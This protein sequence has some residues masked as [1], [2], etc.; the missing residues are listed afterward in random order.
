MGKRRTIVEFV[1]IDNV[2]LWVSFTEEKDNMGADE[3]SAAGDQN[4][5]RCVGGGGGD[6]WWGGAH[7]LSTW[8][9][10]RYWWNLLVEFV[11]MIQN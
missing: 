10:V 2:V 4:V 5:V 9:V 3:A 7:D 8:S 1:E 6:W 11:K